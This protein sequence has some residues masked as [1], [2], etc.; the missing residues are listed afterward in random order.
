MIIDC[1]AHLVPPSLL[2]AIRSQASQF[3]SI[4]Q[5]EDGGSLGFSFAGGKP[6]RPVSKPLS[7]LPARLKWMDEQKIERQMVAPDQRPSGADRDARA[8]LRAVGHRSA[9]GRGARR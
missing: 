6:T 2:E 9:A 5:I 3:P 4:R 1:H 7:D 8:A